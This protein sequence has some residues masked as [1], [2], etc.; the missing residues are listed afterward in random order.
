[1]IEFLVFQVIYPPVVGYLAVTKGRK[2]WTWA[3]IAFFVPV[4]SIFILFALK[5]LPIVVD[6]DE[7]IEQVNDGKVLWRKEGN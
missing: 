6:P 7:Q 4:I 2:Y 5:S 3:I 1:M